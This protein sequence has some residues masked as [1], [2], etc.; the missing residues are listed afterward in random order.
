MIYAGY[1]HL[2]QRI[3]LSALPIKCMAIISR[4]TRVELMGDR[5]APLSNGRQK[6]GH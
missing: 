3:K 4:V 6:S 2:V 5:L 1:A